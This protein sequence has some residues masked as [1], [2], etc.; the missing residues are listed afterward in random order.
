MCLDYMRRNVGQKGG[1][2]DK[3]IKEDIKNRK[4]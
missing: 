4:A 3:E 2:K 1:E